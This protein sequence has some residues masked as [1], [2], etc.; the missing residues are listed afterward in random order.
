MTATAERDQLKE[1]QQQREQRLTE[2]QVICAPGKRGRGKGVGLAG[3]G[4]ASG[5]KYVRG[6]GLGRADITGERSSGV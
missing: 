5:G 2:L 3:E 4:R 6:E 1:E